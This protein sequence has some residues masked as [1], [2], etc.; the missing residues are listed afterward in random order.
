MNFSFLNAETSSTGD[1]IAVYCNKKETDSFLV[2]QLWAYDPHGL[3]LSLVSPEL[4]NDGLCFISAEYVFRVEL[5]SLYLVGL[6]DKLSAPRTQWTATDPWD[7]FLTYAEEH[8]LITQ[9]KDLSGKRIMFGIPAKHTNDELEICRVN[10]D[11]TSRNTSRIKRGRVGLMAVDSDT[12][13]DIETKMCKR[14]A[15]NA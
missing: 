1:W 9:M 13:R 5:D 4:N 14:G 10:R 6:K 2:G 11:G 8:K 15:G 12:E 3:A 7:G